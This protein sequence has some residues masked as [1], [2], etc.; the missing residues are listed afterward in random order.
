MFR[1]G[2]PAESSAMKRYRSYG[3]SPEIREDIGLHGARALDQV[4][5][6]RN[7]DGDPELY[8]AKF[9]AI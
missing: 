1:R 6:R 9:V 3:L 2:E 8:A 4:S 5:P 7:V